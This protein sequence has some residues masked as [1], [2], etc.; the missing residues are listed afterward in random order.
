MDI[1]KEV[2]QV[3]K[4]H[5]AKRIKDFM[6]DQSDSNKP[7]RRELRFFLGAHFPDISEEFIVSC[8]YYKGYA[9]DYCINRCTNKFL[10]YIPRFLALISSLQA[11]LA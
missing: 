5:L 3:D 2:Q 8:I 9:E 10:P 4:E 7:V 6:N 1:I 11:T